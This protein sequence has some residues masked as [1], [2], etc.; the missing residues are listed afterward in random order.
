MADFTELVSKNFNE[1]YLVAVYGTNEEP[2]FKANEIGN[3]I[4]IKNIRDAIKDFD[5]DEKRDDV[6]LTDTIGRTQ[7][8]LFLTENGLYRLLMKSKKPIAR[9]FQKW[10]CNI[11]KELRLT[12]EYKLRQELKEKEEEIKEIHDK[13]SGTNK[14]QHYYMIKIGENLYKLGICSDLQ[15]N[16]SSHT[17]SNNVYGYAYEYK[18]KDPLQSRF[19]EGII[20]NLLARFRTKSNKSTESSYILISWIMIKSFFFQS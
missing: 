16:L 6:G 7:Q 17:R 4:G 10:I 3:I 12:G 13:L 20:K 19:I 9:Q 11:L 2:L 15:S 18:F 14:D 1:N 5:E 8:M